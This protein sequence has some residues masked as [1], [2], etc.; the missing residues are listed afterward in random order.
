[1]AV[2]APVPAVRGTRPRAALTRPGSS[3]RSGRSSATDRELFDR[4]QRDGDRRARDELAVRFLPLARRLARRYAQREEPF[5]DVLQV[6]CLGLVQAIDRFDPARGV[7]F[8]SFAVPTILGEVRRHFRDRTWAVRVPR[9]L[10]EL[11]LR[12]SREVEAL[13]IELNRRPTVPELAHHVG[14][15]EEQVLEALRAGEAYRAT[16][17]DTPCC[18]GEDT[19]VGQLLG[20]DDIGF[21]RAEDRATLG[22]LLGTLSERE[23]R[24]LR[25]RFQEDLTQARIGTAIGVSQMQVS[26]ILRQAV[27]RLRLAAEAPPADQRVP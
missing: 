20:D 6:A 27:G 18:R 1:M 13:S 10:Q 4:L 9:D 12:V 22:P 3:P 17:L 24:V 14:T 25:M 11:T 8:S 19:T 26:R 7:A 15:G 21:D 16:S 23:R 5:D 2:L